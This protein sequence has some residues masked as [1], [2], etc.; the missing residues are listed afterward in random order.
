MRSALISYTKFPSTNVSTEANVSASS[1]TRSPSPGSAIPLISSETPEDRNSFKLLVSNA[2]LESSSPTKE[3]IS[4]SESNA[5]FVPASEEEACDSPAVA[6]EPDTSSDDSALSRTLGSIGVFANA[7]AGTKEN[8]SKA[9]SRSLKQLPPPRSCQQ[10]P[11]S[12]TNSLLK[13]IRTYIL[14]AKYIIRWDKAP[15]RNRE[16][17]MQ[18]LEQPRTLR[19]GSDLSQRQSDRIKGAL[20]HRS[21]A[22]ENINFVDQP[23]IWLNERV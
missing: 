19:D 14:A 1:G 4:A 16:S 22:T 21:R 12:H 7:E 6:T 11:P 17:T 13:R 8:V 10:L 18:G 5:S 15:L 9:A 23:P 3:L 20:R 2:A